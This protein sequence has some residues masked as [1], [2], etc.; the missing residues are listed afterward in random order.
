LQHHHLDLLA[1]RNDL[2]GMD[3]LLGPRHFRH[4]NQTLDARF[5][6][7][8]GAVVGDVGHA[9]HV[10]GFQ[11]VFL[12]HRIPGVILQLLH[13]QADAMGVLVDLDDL[14]LDGFA[15]GQNLFRVIHTAPGHVGDVQQAI[16]T[17][18]IDEGAV[19][20]DVLDH[21]VDD[22]AFVQLADHLGA[23]FGTRFFQDG[24]ARHHDVA[25]P[26]IHFQDLE[27]LLEPHQRAGIA[28]GAHIDLA[29]GQE[30]HGA[31][32]IHGKATLDAAK[33]GAIDAV[34]G[35]IGFLKAIPSRFA[36][37]HLAADHSLAAGVLDVAQVDLDLIANRDF[38]GLAGICEFFQI[39]TAFHLVADID[40]GLPR[41]DGDDLA[42]DDTALFG[43]IDF[44]A[45]VQEGFEFLHR[46][47]SAHEF[48]VSF[49]GVLLAV[50]L[51]PPVL[52]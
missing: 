3:V 6:F 17:A 11:R 25:T 47:F 35:S 29:A 48:L 16:H 40:D 26:A 31:A 10:D 23:L 20:G 51:S 46:G 19:F 44:E 45:F 52:G 12:F 33:D 32:Q 43:G 9:A 37:R 41:L 39:D 50:R 28:H 13:A 36:A 38:R 15:N 4:V 2:A 1:G 7:H 42:F 18:Q 22:I 8:E 14:N 5:Q 21:A 30:R 24:A 49:F 34:L 27:G